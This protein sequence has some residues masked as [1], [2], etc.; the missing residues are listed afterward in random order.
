MSLHYHCKHCGT[1]IG[2]LDQVSLHTER[3][4]FHKLTEEERQ[5]MIEYSPSG[6]IHIKSIC[7]DCQ[8]ALQRNPDLY[9]LDYIIQ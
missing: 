2:S 9:D 6:D 8:E 5:E 1:K 3:L 4:G 7:E